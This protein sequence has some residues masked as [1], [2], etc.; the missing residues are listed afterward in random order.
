MSVAVVG[1]SFGSPSFLLTCLGVVVE[2]I[3]IVVDGRDNKTLLINQTNRVWIRSKVDS[4]RVTCLSKPTFGEVGDGDVVIGWVV[5]GRE[6]AV[7]V[8]SEEW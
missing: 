7:L 3:L 5:K 6:E 2:V 1:G 4:N 8:L